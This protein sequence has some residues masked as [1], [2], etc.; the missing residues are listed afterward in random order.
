MRRRIESQTPTPSAPLAERVQRSR[1]AHADTLRRLIAES[2]AVPR[3]KVLHR[4]RLELKTIRYQEE[5]LLRRPAS[6]PGLIRQLRRLQ[7]VLGEYEDL[8]QFRKLAR[9]LDLRCASEMDEPWRQARQRARAVP[10][11]LSNVLV[12]LAGSLV[13]PVPFEQ[14][15]R[16]LPDRPLDLSRIV[17]IL[18]A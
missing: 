14:P 13:R 15:R 17:D 6:L 18:S 4:I 7:T 3:R 12:L 2:G 8:V 5:R 9:S 1:N 11:H 10:A 16:A